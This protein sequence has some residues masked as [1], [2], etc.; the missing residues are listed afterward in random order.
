MP[1]IRGG[2]VKTKKPK[3][4]KKTPTPPPTAYVPP[5]RDQEARTK[6]EGRQ[7]PAP[8]P[9]TT[10][11]ETVGAIVGETVAKGNLRQRNRFFA[12]IRLPRRR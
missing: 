1:I 8:N 9:I 12:I 6:R 5:S 7:T 10:T 2:P 4:P 3:P 11:L